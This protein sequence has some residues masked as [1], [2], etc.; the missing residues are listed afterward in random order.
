[1]ACIMA[2]LYVAG[3]VPFDLL[4]TRHLT[5]QVDARLNERLAEVVH[6]KLHLDA[7]GRL[8]PDKDVDD[9]PVVRGI[10]DVEGDDMEVEGQALGCKVLKCLK[11]FANVYY[12]FSAGDDFGWPGGQSNGCDLLSSYWVP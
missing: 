2:A 10:G 11:L 9:A 8:P 5:A 7:D 1:M 3:V 12:L 6:G 4:Y